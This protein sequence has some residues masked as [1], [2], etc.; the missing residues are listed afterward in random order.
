M[1]NVTVIRNDGAIGTVVGEEER[2]FLIIDFNSGSS[3]VVP[4]EILILQEDGTYY[5]EVDSDELTNLVDNSG[6]ET[7]E[8]EQII[9]VIAE[10]LHIE[11]ERVARGV[12]RVHKRVETREEIVNTTTTEEKVSVERIPV[13]QLIEE[14]E[15]P[16]VRKEDGVLIIPVIEEVIVLEKRLMFREEVRISRHRTKRTIPHKVILR[17]EAVD[18]E[19]SDPDGTEII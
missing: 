3:L 5:L 6:T 10:E 8:E 15:A 11:T 16:K 7:L 2:G 17:R 18:I 9:Q 12:V 4:P 1:K 13:N 14:D 19:R